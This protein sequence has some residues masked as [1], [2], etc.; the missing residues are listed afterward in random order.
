MTYEDAS[1]IVDVIDASARNDE[2]LCRLREQIL[3]AAISYARIRADWSMASPETRIEMDGR[4]RAAHNA[5]ID[6]CNILSRAMHKLGKDIAWRRILGQDR[7]QIGDF[8]CWLH[9]ILGVRAR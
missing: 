6:A 4:R 5:L 2:L 7:K 1:M 8:A 9:A 3:A